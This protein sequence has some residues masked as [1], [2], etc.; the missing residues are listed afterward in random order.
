MSSRVGS[1]AVHHQ[2]E[3][4]ADEMRLM[5]SLSVRFFMALMY[6]C[7]SADG[8]RLLALCSLQVALDL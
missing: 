1:R 7:H 8:C 6:G 2:V 3:R 5:P 4:R